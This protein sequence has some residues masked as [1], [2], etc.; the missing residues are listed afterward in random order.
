MV[1]VKCLRLGTGQG[2]IR[3]PVVG[4]NPPSCATRLVP[5]LQRRRLAARGSDLTSVATRPDSPDVL[6]ET[7]YARRGDV[8]VAYQEFVVRTA[9]LSDAIA[10]WYL[11]RV[12]KDRQFWFRRPSAPPKSAR[13]VPKLLSV[14]SR[15]TTQRAQLPPRFAGWERALG[16]AVS[17]CQ[18]TG[19]R[20]PEAMRLSTEPVPSDVPSFSP[21]VS[22]R[23]S[24][25]CLVT[26]STG[27]RT[28]GLVKMLRFHIHG[29][30]SEEWGSK[31]WRTGRSP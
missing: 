15:S 29:K 19:G 27:R 4:A 23:D 9:R 18:T 24:W 8:H 17:P 20:H 6:P 2:C 22:D 14:S 1:H 12:T 28:D 3:G 16:G 7:G 10:I 5:T 26:L 11:I 13:E 25:R 31:A 30:A 21:R